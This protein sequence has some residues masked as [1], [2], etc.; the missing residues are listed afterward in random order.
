MIFFN[1]LNTYLLD[2]VSILPRE[3]RCSSPLGIMALGRVNAQPATPFIVQRVF[4]ENQSLTLY[5]A[6]LF[7]RLTLTQD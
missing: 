1:I 6:V 2:D 5:F 7:N 3:T 4:P